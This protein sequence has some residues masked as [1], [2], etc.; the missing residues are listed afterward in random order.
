MTELLEQA[1]AKVKNLPKNEQDTI[2]AIVLEELEDETKWE[3]AFA[4]SHDAIDAI[5]PYI[6]LRSVRAISLRH[7]YAGVYTIGKR[8]NAIEI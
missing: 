5:A 4:N 6:N 1:I 2:T 7:D 8:P 3:Q